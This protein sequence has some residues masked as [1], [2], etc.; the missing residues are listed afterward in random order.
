[1]GSLRVQFVLLGTKP[2]LQLLQYFMLET[3][4]IRMDVEGIFSPSTKS[5]L[6]RKLFSASLERRIL[7]LNSSSRPV[8]N[9]CFETQIM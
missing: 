3:L 9:E 2:P 7:C 5:F 6:K 1:M 8:G 4:V